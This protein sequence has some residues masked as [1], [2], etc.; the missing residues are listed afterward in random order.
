[1]DLLYLRVINMELRTLKI[2][3]FILALLLFSLMPANK[4]IDESVFKFHCFTKRVYN[5]AE[6]FAAD[7]YILATSF[8]SLLA[9]LAALPKRQIVM[10]KMNDGVA[11]DDLLLG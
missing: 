2:G 1:M 10:I 5:P 11:Q 6:R 4:S 9:R 3:L 7:D 8:N